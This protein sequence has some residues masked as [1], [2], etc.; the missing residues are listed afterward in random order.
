MNE[1]KLYVK[2]YIWTIY[3]F[4]IW[5]DLM[6][7]HN[8]TGRTPVVMLKSS[9]VSFSTLFH[10][11]EMGTLSLFTALEYKTSQVDCIFMLDRITECVSVHLEMILQCEKCSDY[12]RRVTL[13]DS[14]FGW[15]WGGKNSENFFYECV[16]WSWNLL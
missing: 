11:N 16:L 15:E 13:F 1:A 10:T 6:N 8:V 12:V 7:R 2:A 5:H 4:I 14:P 3:T 9:V